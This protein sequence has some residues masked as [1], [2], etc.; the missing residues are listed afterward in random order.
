MLVYA[1]TVVGS[2]RLV[3]RVAA[4]GMGLV[5]RAEHLRLGRTAA[6]KLVPLHRAGPDELRRFEREA[7]SV[8]QLEHPNILA[9][10]DYGEQDGV[11]YLVM[12]YIRGGTLKELLERGPV[13]RGTALPYLR[14]P[15]DA[16][17][18]AHEQGI[19]HR[20][21]KPAN[22]LLDE[23]RARSTSPTS[24]SPRCSTRRAADA[25]PA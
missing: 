9:L 10:W 20:D 13:P 16:L 5:F 19:V 6:V 8:A 23:P 2:Y 24:G 15:A 1:P 21:V 4:G 25:G 3:E 11:P 22:V 18:Y 14:Q 17:D 12:P 7:D